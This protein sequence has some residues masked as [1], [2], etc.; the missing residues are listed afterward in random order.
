[1]DLSSVLPAQPLGRFLHAFAGVTIASFSVGKLS[2]TDAAVASYA[3][4]SLWFGIPPKP[5][6]AVAGSME[7]LVGLGLLLVA[8]ATPREGAASKLV[9][10]A[11]PLSYLGLA[12]TMSGALF[13]ELVVRPFEKPGLLGIGTILMAFAVAALLAWWQARQASSASG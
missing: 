7:A 11:G 12:G 13:V 8:I 6:M 2:M 10:L 1:M 5:F 4:I 9:G 3:E